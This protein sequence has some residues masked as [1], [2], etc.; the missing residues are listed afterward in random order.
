M[1]I[2]IFHAC[3]CKLQLAL[4]VQIRLSR[5]S[6]LR[7]INKRARSSLLKLDEGAPIEA[8]PF[9]GG[10]TTM[11]FHHIVSPLILGWWTQNAHHFIALTVQVFNSS[12]VYKTYIN[13][14]DDCE[15][16]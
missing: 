8:N 5:S 9:Q 13:T 7:T 4:L 16:F 1:A 6:N 14:L 2:R 3:K 15:G 10:G 11:F 12:T